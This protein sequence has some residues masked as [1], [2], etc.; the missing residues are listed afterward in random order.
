[1]FSCVVGTLLLGAIV[2][3]GIFLYHKVEQLDQEIAQQRDTAI[4][5]GD[6][7]DS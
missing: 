6:E 7:G 3:G 1:M 2:V 4:F 5:D